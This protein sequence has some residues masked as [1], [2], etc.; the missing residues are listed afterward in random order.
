MAVR[1]CCHFFCSEKKIKL[2][3]FR[4]AYAA[5]NLALTEAEILYFLALAKN[6]DW[7]GWQD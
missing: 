4:I 1:K 5:R 3:S 6:K 7:S 2:H